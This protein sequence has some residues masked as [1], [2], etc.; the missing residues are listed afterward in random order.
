MGGVATAPFKAT[1]A[2]TKARPST[3]LLLAAELKQAA[4]TR[5]HPFETICTTPGR[6]TSAVLKLT[7]KA[8]KM[9]VPAG[10][11]SVGLPLL[12]QLQT[13]PVPFHTHPAR[14]GSAV[15]PGAN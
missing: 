7:Q 6:D 1:K 12:M 11:A 5:V 10:T 14:L 3:S 13:Q 8:G 4:S 2:V 15:L 9:P